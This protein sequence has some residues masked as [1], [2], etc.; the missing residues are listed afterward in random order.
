MDFDDDKNIYLSDFE[1]EEYFSWNPNKHLRIEE[2]DNFFEEKA[3]SKKKIVEKR[4]KRK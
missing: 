2:N 4:E 1:D 3:I